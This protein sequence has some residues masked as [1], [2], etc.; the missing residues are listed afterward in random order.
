[1]THTAV[2]AAPAV[3]ALLAGGGERYI[4]A[5][6]GGGG[7]SRLILRNM[8]PAARLLAMDCDEFAAARAAEIDDNRFCFLR[9]NFS[10]IAAA[11]GE[12][13]MPEVSGVLFDLGVSSMQLDTAVRGM[14]LMREGPLDM[15]MDR[16]GGMTAKTILE[17]YAERDLADIL[18]R[19]GE[20]PESRRIA[21]V[22]HKRRYEVT[23]TAALAKLV[24]ETKRARPLKRHPATLVFQALRIAVNGELDN[25]RRGLAAARDILAHGGRLVVIAFHSLEDRIVKRTLMPPA[26]PGIGR[27]GGGMRPLGKTSPSAEE[28]QLNPR[29]RSARMRVFV[30]EAA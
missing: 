12:V 23:D 22:L 15:R 9:E 25:L 5:T 28:T 30:K 20:E 1:M 27:I 21:R 17:K 14:S 4:D 7:H 6:F 19:Y 29:A 26:F 10:K 13:E 24:A 11:A 18:W 8:P 3:E 16:R 2:L